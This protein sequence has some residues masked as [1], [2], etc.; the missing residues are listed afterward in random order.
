LTNRFSG[1][2]G[3]DEK[4]LMEP[5]KLIAVTIKGMQNDKLEIYPGVARVLLN[6]SRI[7]PAFMRKQL[8]KAGANEMAG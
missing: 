6:M 1:T 4:T 8:S 2:E 3:F 5:A 7:A